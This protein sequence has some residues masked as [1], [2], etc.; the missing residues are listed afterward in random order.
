M[1]GHFTIGAITLKKLFERYNLDQR[2]TELALD[3][4]AVSG[5][6]Y[7]SRKTASNRIPVIVA[8]SGRASL[9]ILRWDLVPSWWKKSLD[10]KK[11]SSY[12]ARSD[13]LLEKATFKGAWKKGQRCIIPA[14]MFFEW[15]DKQLMP[16]GA[17][18]REQKIEVTDV[19]IFSMAGIWD[20][21]VA[22][23]HKGLRSCAIITT[24]ANRLLA[25]IP[26]TRMPVIL[27]ADK[28]KAWLDS[29]TSPEKA[30]DMLQKYPQEQMKIAE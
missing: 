26:H 11:Y 7:P 10:E 23:E 17:Q 8:N 29:K 25:S 21:C 20:E 19:Q 2:Q 13:S 9:E 24:G 3:D 22:G 14:T 15:P 27:P 5:G 30:F 18:R 12:N 1:C 4:K 16:R 28:E 6:F